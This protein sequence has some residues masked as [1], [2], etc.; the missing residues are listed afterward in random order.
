MATILPNLDLQKNKRPILCPK[1]GQCQIGKVVAKNSFLA[2]VQSRIYIHSIPGQPY[3]RFMVEVQGVRYQYEVHG[4]Q[5]SFP[6]F[7]CDSGKRMLLLG[8]SGTG[9]TTLLHLMCGLLQPQSGSLKVANLELNGAA[10]RTLDRWRGTEIGVVFQR[11]HF[12]QSLSVAENLVLPHQLAH[13]KVKPEVVDNMFAM[14]DRLGIAHRSHARPHN[15]S[16]GEQQRASIARALLHRPKVV[17]ADEPTSA[18]D[19]RNTK[20]VMEIIER[21]AAEATLVVVTHDQRLKDRYTSCV[22]LPSIES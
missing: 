10:S 6:D 3:L 17:F 16:V 2:E 7:R 12:V 15:L 18:L 8:D 19:D 14:L 20:T 1:E 13:G 11:P 4:Q 22:T 9:K 21:E 5:L